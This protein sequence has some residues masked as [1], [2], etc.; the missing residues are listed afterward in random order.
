MINAIIFD[1]DGLLV[2]SEPFWR[3]AE[4]EVFSEVNIEL[5][6][7]MCFKTVGLRIDE[8]V[9]YW[10]NKFPWSH[11]SKHDVVEMILYRMK[12]L[13]E[14][15]AEAMAGVYKLLTYF[16][17]KNIV[18]AI[19]SASPMILIDAVVNK[20]NIR[21]YFSEICSAE[22]EQYGKPHP[23]IYIHTAQ[24]LKVKPY[25]CLVFED[26]FNGIIAAKAARMKV[27]AVPE[28]VLRG[29]LKFHAAD[30]VLNSLDDYTDEI[31]NSLCND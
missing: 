11:I 2:N 29:E 10:Y 6:D 14:Q 1:M 22:N 16:N 4:K 3:E 30:C 7:E 19:A 24:K 27:I 18:M 28:D 26:S 25:E 8:V 21:N 15:K 20:L 31:F 23:K 9:A 5:T 12:E 13:I 17:N